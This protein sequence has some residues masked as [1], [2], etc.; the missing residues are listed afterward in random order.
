MN[1]IESRVCA[2]WTE[3]A[4][5][6]LVIRQKELRDPI[7][8]LWTAEFRKY[9]PVDQILNILDVGTGTGYFSIL[10]AKEGHKVTG[11]DLT[12]AMIEGAKKMAVAESVQAEFCVMNAQELEFNEGTFDAVVTRNLTWTLPDPVKAYSEWLRVLKPGGVLMN[13]DADYANSVRNGG[14]VS[15]AGKKDNIYCHDRIDQRLLQ[16]NAEITLSMPVSRESRPDWDINCLKQLG[17][18]SCGSDLSA[19]ERIQRELVNIH[20]PLFL[21]WAKK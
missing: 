17:V 19:G 12:P 4:D 15:K 13:F 18:A 5:D 14:E 21:V 11:I 3:R 1:T 8:A 16:E 7:T 20:S 2:Y 10:L 9:L 6:F